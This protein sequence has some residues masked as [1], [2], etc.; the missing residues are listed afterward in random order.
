VGSAA[1]GND[2][3]STSSSNTTAAAAAAAVQ[4]IPAI[5]LAASNGSWL[6]PVLSR[7][8]VS[9]DHEFGAI[10]EGSY[11]GSTAV[12]VLIASCR[13]WVAHAGDSRA[14]LG[15]NGAVQVLTSD[16]KAS[17]GDEV[18]RVQVRSVQQ[19]MCFVA[20]LAGTGPAETGTN[21]HNR[22]GCAGGGCLSA[23]MMLSQL[24]SV[25]HY[26][27]SLAAPAVRPLINRCCIAQ[28]V[29]PFHIDH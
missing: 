9:L 12:V 25:A 5:D 22:H 3:A 26:T 21:E 18:A 6:L 16:H 8:F 13:M 2:T 19:H 23:R 27:V 10:S 15:R 17:R 29:L 4:P 11:V 14:V 7:S 24:H 28:W 1:A 20:T